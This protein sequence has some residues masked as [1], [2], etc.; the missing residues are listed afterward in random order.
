MR[1]PAMI[2][3]LGLAW[4]ALTVIAVTTAS[5]PWRITLTIAVA[6]YGYAYGWT[7]RDSEIEGGE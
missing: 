3:L 1:T 7:L 5:T 6:V 2:A 4:L